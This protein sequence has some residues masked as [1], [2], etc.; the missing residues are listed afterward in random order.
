ME[1]DD[2]IPCVW[3][4]LFNLGVP[5]DLP[6]SP[7]RSLITMHYLT[8]YRQYHRNYGGSRAL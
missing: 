7:G 8:N 5:G 4:D 2:E 1:Q 6:H 3:P